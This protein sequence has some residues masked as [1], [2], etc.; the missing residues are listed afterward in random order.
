LKALIDLYISRNDSRIDELTSARRP[1]RPKEKELLDLEE[2]RRR[3]LKEF[4]TGFG[5]SLSSHA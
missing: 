4:D 2:V 5:E 3:E 1:G